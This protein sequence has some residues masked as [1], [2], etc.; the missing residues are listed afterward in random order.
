MTQIGFCSAFFS[1][2]SE[3]WTLLGLNISLG[4]ISYWGACLSLVGALALA[5]SKSLLFFL[6]SKDPSRTHPLTI[7]FHWFAWPAIAANTLFSYFFGERGTGF[8]ALFTWKSTSVTFLFSTLGNLLCV[9]LILTSVPGDAPLFDLQLIRIL[10]LSHMIFMLFNFFGDLISVN[11]TRHILDKMVTSQRKYLQ[12]LFLDI[13]GIFLGYL[14][15]L[16]PSI[17]TILYAVQTNS[18]LNPLIHTGLFGNALIPFFLLIFATTNMGVPFTVFALL[19]IF[20]IAIPTAIYLFLFVAVNVCHHIF[21]RFPLKRENF[22]PMGLLY[23]RSLGKFSMFLGG[24][25]MLLATVFMGI[26]WKE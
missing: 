14:V 4:D 12:Y 19:A 8:R 18:N 2:L 15:T 21:R 22:I 1:S 23:V 3:V 25:A 9:M 16:I 13:F 20:S 17:F 26:Q 5:L 11:V 7:Q 24:I 6:T 10:G